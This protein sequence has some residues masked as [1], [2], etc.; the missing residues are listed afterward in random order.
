MT[1][2]LAVSM[3]ALESPAFAALQPSTDL[4]LGVAPVLTPIPI[5]E[6]LS[7]VRG[8][9]SGSFVRH[10]KAPSAHDAIEAERQ[11]ALLAPPDDDTLHLYVAGVAG[12]VL[13]TLFML[14]MLSRKPGQD[15]SVKA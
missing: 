12:L 9:S 4:G 6:R 15:P 2:A 10:A 5:G 1:V 8:G 13:I 11:N 14:A 3:L 7:T